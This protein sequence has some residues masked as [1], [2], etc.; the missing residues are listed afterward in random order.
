MDSKDG[1]LELANHM[2]EG[3]IGKSESLNEKESFSASPTVTLVSRPSFPLRGQ[4]RE[5]AIALKTLTAL[6]R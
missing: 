6:K 4:H 3:M 1:R 2:E 5:M